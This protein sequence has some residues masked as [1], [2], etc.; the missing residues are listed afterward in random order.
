MTYLWIAIAVLLGAASL[1]GMARLVVGPTI[2]DRA[3]SVDVLLASAI[4][5]IGAWAAFHR[6]PTVL[7]VLLVLSLLGFVGSISISRFVARKQRDKAESHER[8]GT[9]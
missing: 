7:P 1:L 8:S 5:G 2:L 9:P 6:D 3:L 4:A